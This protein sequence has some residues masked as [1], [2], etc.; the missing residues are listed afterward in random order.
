MELFRVDYALVGMTHPHTMMLLPPANAQINEKQKIAVGGQDGVLQVFGLN[1]DE[2]EV[3]FKT[4]PGPEIT[5]M[6]LGG[7][8]GTPAD[9]IFIASGNEVRAFTKRGKQFLGFDTNLTEPIRSM[10]VSG[11][12][13]LVCGNH[14]MG[15]FKD[16]K[17]AG[18]YL[19]GD[20]IV[21]VVAVRPDL[22]S[23]RLTVVLACS[24]RALRVLEHCRVLSTLE[25][26][27]VPT[28]LQVVP[29]SS[30]VLCGM[31]DGTISWLALDGRAALSPFVETTGASVTCLDANIDPDG[32]GNSTWKLLVARLDG[33]IQMYNVSSTGS[34][35]NQ[36]DLAYYANVNE[37]VS[38]LRGGIVG[39]YGKSELIACTFSGRIIGL[40]TTPPTSTI[41][42]SSDISGLHANDK[43]ADKLKAEIAELEQKVSRERSR[44]QAST[45][46][47]SLG[48]SSIPALELR[49]M[50]VLSRE[51][52]C[53]SLSLEAPTALDFVLI[54]SDV[55]IDL[56][57][58]PDTTA[59]VSKS[60]CEPGSGNYLLATYRCQL[61]T[62]RLEIRFRT[63]EGQ[64]GYLT[65][66]VT[67]LL[68]PKCC[69]IRK[70]LIRPLSLHTRTH[71]P[72]DD[73][74]PYNRLHLRGPF[75]LAE[76]HS[77]LTYCIPEVP[78]RPETRGAGDD[79][80]RY[81][82]ISTLTRTVIDCEYGRG[83]AEIKS[84]NISTIAVL[85]DILTKEATKKNIR[86]DIAC[87]QF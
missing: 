63:M 44:Y 17:D 49:D 33:T 50:L 76:M 5:S 71:I 52:A 81:T 15:H 46:S 42:T 66:H 64:H 35:D 75:S 36:P 73:D 31:T 25:T 40:T 82:F 87:S 47:N 20:S 26:P 19:C 11:S 60:E 21:D 28:C 10:F 24:G 37:G 74:R 57:D 68:Q 85:K 58:S 3:T 51:D 70:Y 59:V 13:L 56:L 7:A 41:G 80:A 14:I 29:N 86:L 8:L 55:P 16:C 69:Q 23:P 22:N 6:Q 54:Q 48:T 2:I 9:K 4:I 78:E 39:N 18:T 27:A 65:V 38:S 62:T 43:R 61:N 84:D 83:E 72:P 1:N 77:W 45:Q 12:D 32:G 67:P 53:Y 79:R 30:A 34:Y